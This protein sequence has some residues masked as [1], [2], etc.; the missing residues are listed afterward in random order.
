MTVNLGENLKK[1]R[2]EKEL[3]QE[4]LANLLGISGQAVS[5]WERGESYPDITLLPAIAA[6][7]GVSVDSLLGVDKSIREQEIQAEMDCYFQLNHAGD[8]SQ[9]KEVI[10][11]AVS[12][13]PGDFRLLVRLM[14]AII[15]DENTSDDG[16]MSEYSQVKS[17]Y[18]SIQNYCVDDSIRMWSK[19]LI[20]T[21]YKRLQNVKDSGVT[22][23]AL[24]EII[25]QM[26]SMRNSCDYIS[27]YIL[28]P[29]KEHDDAC[30]TAIDELVYLLCGVMVNYCYYDDRFTS[31]YKIGVMESQ[32][33]ILDGLY[34]CGDYG[35]NYIQTIYRF[36]HLGHLYH[37]IGNDK[38]ALEN[39]SKCA[40]L[41]KKYDALPEV[42]QRTSPLFAGMT[43]NKANTPKSHSE[44][45]SQR[46]KRLMLE[47]YPLSA[48]FKGSENF[49]RIIESLC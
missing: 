2:A 24:T 35:K 46:I 20:C 49:K 32:N 33:K 23:E 14:E 28:A 10:K 12:E 13:F 19:R 4:A 48:E 39:L 43:F 40:E 38:K 47:K 34:P 36:G 30:R 8:F 29:G 25:A 18:E 26:P 37:E 6:L 27:T 9:A 17:I 31:E 41:A 1:L 15:I 42:S 7:F 11:R 5:K 16:A 45:M 44:A 22:S 21:V 3:T